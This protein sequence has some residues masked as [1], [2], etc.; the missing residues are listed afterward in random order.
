M[1][2]EKRKDLDSEKQKRLLQRLVEE[3]TRSEID[4]YYR[5]TS[6]IAAFLEKYIRKD[7]R[8]SADDRSLLQRLSRR[9]IEVLLSLH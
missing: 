5:P 6:E 4:L 2:E 3:L 9:D 8:L 1:L 7:A